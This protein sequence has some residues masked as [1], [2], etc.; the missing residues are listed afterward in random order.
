MEDHGFDSRIEEELDEHYGVDRGNV[1]EVLHNVMVDIG[2][3]EVKQ[4]ICVLRYLPAKLILER[5]WGRSAHAVFANED[6]GSYT[7]T[8]RS[9][10][11]MRK[12]KFLASPAEHKRNHEFVRVK[13]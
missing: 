12:V 7:V 11:H 3:I 8:I 5:P 6:D 9:P 10:D 4:H 13:E 1:L 2:R